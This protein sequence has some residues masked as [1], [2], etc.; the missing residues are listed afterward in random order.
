MFYEIDEDLEIPAHVHGAQWGVVLEG[1]MEMSIGD[2]TT[3]YSKGD[4]YYVP[5]GILHITRIKGGYRGID[6]FADSDRY[7]PKDTP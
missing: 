5:P 4:T 7:L 6:I 2:D 3:T 1:S